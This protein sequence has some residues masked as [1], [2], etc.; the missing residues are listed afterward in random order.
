MKLSP[1]PRLDNPAAK[2]AVRLFACAQGRQEYE[3]TCGMSTPLFESEGLSASF[4]SGKFLFSAF[5][6]K[7]FDLIPMHLLR[8]VGREVRALAVIVSSSCTT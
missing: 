7:F 2:M 1:P 4:F 6:L 3:Y 5:M 8:E